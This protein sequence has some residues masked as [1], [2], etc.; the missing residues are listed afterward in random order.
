MPEEINR[1]VTDSVTDYF[2]TTTPWAGKNL[3]KSGVDKSKI[4][5]VGNVMI[6]TLLANLDRLKTPDV[7]KEMKLNPQQYFVMTMHRPANVDEVEKLMAF[8][9]AIS[10]NVRNLP[11]IFPI[12][13]RTRQIIEGGG[14]T[15]CNIHPIDPLGYL[16]SIS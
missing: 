13:P 5:F 9:L 8:T 1:I 6:D 11:V 15:A 10:N 2:F 14:I 4:F 7:W 3:L 16:D 12:H